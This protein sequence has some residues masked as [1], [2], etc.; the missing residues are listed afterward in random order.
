MGYLVKERLNHANSRIH[1]YASLYRSDFGDIY[2]LAK[3]RFSLAADSGL[4]QIPWIFNVPV[5]Y[6]NAA[7]PAGRA[8]WRK[9]DLFL[10]KRIWFREKERFMTYPE[11]LRLGADEWNQSHFYEDAA[12]DIVENTA[13]EI[14]DIVKELMARLEGTWV[15]TDEDEHLHR[16][17]ASLFSPQHRCFGFLSR[18]GTQFLRDN[19]ALI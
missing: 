13:D 5:A 1:D 9:G 17:Y 16:K 14:L 19:R 3:C 15:S 4:T 18:I 2:L 6:T 10:P 12:T 11:M 8:A 7:P